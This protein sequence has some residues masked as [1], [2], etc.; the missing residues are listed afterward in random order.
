MCQLT[1]IFKTALSKFFSIERDNILNNISERNLC[2]R[3][4]IYLEQAQKSEGLEGYFADVE[5]NR[6]DGK[7][8]TIIDEQNHEL[9]ITCDLLLHSRGKKNKDNLIAIE[10]KK[11]SQSH[12][13]LEQDRIRLRSMT[14]PIDSGIYSA[15]GATVPEHVCGYELGFFIV[16]DTVNSIYLLEEY[17]EGILI[18]STEDQIL[19]Q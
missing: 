3:L 13:E 11:A 5:Y 16:L 12:H 18:R 1:R 15:D 2:G 7:I 9:S 4:A 19:R 14:K 10:M 17:R 6:K 8:K